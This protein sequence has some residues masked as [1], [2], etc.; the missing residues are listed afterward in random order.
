[1]QK[2]SRGALF[3]SWLILLGMLTAVA[4][5]SIDM[6]LPGFPA[7]ARS[8]GTD[9]PSVQ[10][11]LAFFLVGI[12]LGQLIYGPLSDRYGRKPPLYVGLTVYIAASVVCATAHCVEVLI[13][14]R[15]FQAL[16]G[17]AGLVIGRAVIRDRT[18]VEEGAKA[19]SMLILVMGLA[20]ILAPLF[21]GLLLKLASWRMIFWVLL[22]FACLL[23]LAVHF[24]MRETLRRDPHSRLSF[25]STARTYGSL[26]QDRR[27]ITCSLTGAFNYGGMFA[28]IASSPYVLIEIYGVPSEDFGW[29]FG[30][31]AFGFIAAS[32]LNARLVSRVG[33]VRLLRRAIWI[34]LGAAAL[35]LVPILLGVHSLPLFMLSLFCYVATL[36][37]I[38]PNAMALGMAEQG[39]R[40][41]AA[42]ALIGTLQFMIGTI[43]GIVVSA[44]HSSTA[45][46]LSAVMGLFAASGLLMYKLGAEPTLLPHSPPA[47]VPA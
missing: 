44:L 27:F 42:S 5:L 20:P 23:L 16:G 28:Y 12:S 10:L 41:G 47:T 38:G 11:T 19:F 21:G 29:L 1:L 22:G 15:L 9:L 18:T 14:A 2:S 26:L 25:A 8:L 39:Q 34:P 6:Y 24:T 13:V 37:F 7:I 35:G 40:A 32:Q 30:L 31:N 46:P 4:P 17:S 3:P 33:T 36:G 45:L 43:A